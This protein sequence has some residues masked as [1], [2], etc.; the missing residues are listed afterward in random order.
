MS[1]ESPEEILGQQLWIFISPFLFIIGV[2]GN[3]T[4]LFILSG[5]SFKRSSVSFSLSAL[6]VVDTGVLVTSLLRH[7]ISHV[8][9]IDIRVLFG[10]AGCKIHVLLSYYLAQLSSW[11]LVLVTTERAMSVIDPLSIRS[12]S[13][14]RSKTIKIWFAMAFLLFTINSNFIWTTELTYTESD[15]SYDNSTNEKSYLFTNGSF[16]DVNEEV[17]NNLN[18]SDEEKESF[19]FSFDQNSK[20]LTENESDSLSNKKTWQAQCYFSNNYYYF[21]EKVWPSMDFIICVTLPFLIIAVCNVIILIFVYKTVKIRKNDQFSILLK[22]QNLDQPTSTLSHHVM[23][24]KGQLRDLKKQD[25]GDFESKISNDLTGNKKAEAIFLKKYNFPSLPVKEYYSFDP[26]ETSSRKNLSTPIKMNSIEAGRLYH[27]VSDKSKQ[28]NK[29]ETENDDDSEL[30]SNHST[31]EFSQAHKNNQTIPKNNLNLQNKVE[32]KYFHSF[33]QLP[34]NKKS[35]VNQQFRAVQTTR[36]PGPPLTSFTTMLLS[37][38]A[39]FLLTNAPCG[40]YFILE[41]Y[42]FRHIKED[43]QAGSLMLAHA[44]VNLLNFAN[45]SANFLL[46]CMTGSKFRMA[47]KLKL[48]S[49]KRVMCFFERFF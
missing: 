42:Y 22:K 31:P 14:N 47:L 35:T 27:N 43:R 29:D 48:K 18:Y 37:L 10:H 45:Y 28:F 40:I 16:L 20:I 7:W 44:I 8:A 36:K 11:T 6:A 21:T 25:I 32:S 3:L 39:C 17:T 5:K 4:S 26:L 15:D 2:F 23:S 12:I 49:L 30:F 41:D 19:L 9:D 13:K 46:Y 34:K 24:E 33:N 1:D 38:G